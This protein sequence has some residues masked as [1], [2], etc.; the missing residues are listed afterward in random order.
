MVTN[1]VSYEK[2]FLSVLLKV[3]FDAI[4]IW[5]S[6]EVARSGQLKTPYSRAALSVRTLISCDDINSLSRSLK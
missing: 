5:K 1:E 6:K 3:S 4:R 2:D